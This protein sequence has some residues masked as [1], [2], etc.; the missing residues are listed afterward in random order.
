LALEGQDEISGP[1]KNTQMKSLP[2]QLILSP[3]DQQ[4]VSLRPETE[5]GPALRPDSNPNPSE[6][7]DL[8]DSKIDIRTKGKASD[9]NRDK[10]GSAGN[11]KPGETTYNNNVFIG[12]NNAASVIRNNIT[13]NTPPSNQH[14]N[15]PILKNSGGSRI[16]INNNIMTKKRPANE[17][18]TEVIINNNIIMNPYSQS[19]TH[20]SQ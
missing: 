15:L 8:Q 20:G 12:E 1:T 5:F 14:G 18:Q 2:D 19:V 7:L 11:E 10:M 17:Q 3:K 4:V 6:N 9:K 13:I 16:I